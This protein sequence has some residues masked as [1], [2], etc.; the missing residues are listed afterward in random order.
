[1]YFSLFYK[2]NF[3]SAWDVFKTKDKK[4]STPFSQKPYVIFVLCLTHWKFTGTHFN[5]FIAS[6][7]CTIRSWS[8][9]MTYRNFLAEIGW[10]W[11][12]CYNMLFLHIIPFSFFLASLSSLFLCFLCASDSDL[13]F[14]SVYFFFLS[15][16][17]WTTHV[18]HTNKI[19]APNPAPTTAIIGV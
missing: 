6:S 2:Y 9:L 5:S 16:Q 10:L 7:A 12:L 3:L 11:W 13:L 8:S 18:Q 14:T 4:Y 1:M 19:K 15:H 17:E